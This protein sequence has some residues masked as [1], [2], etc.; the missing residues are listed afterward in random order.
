M[1]DK[2]QPSF[3]F[4]ASPH[5]LRPNLDHYVAATVSSLRSYYHVMPRGDDF[6][7]YAEFDKAYKVLNDK[8]NQFSAFTAELVCQA[9]EEDP[10]VF[11]VLRCILGFSPPELA[12]LAGTE[13]GLTITQGFARSLDQRARARKPLFRKSNDTVRKRVNA[14][15]RIACETI[16]VGAPQT[17]QTGLHRL[18]KVDTGGGLSTLKSVAREKVPYPMLLYERFLGRPF[19]S[20]R[21]AVSERVGDVIEAEIERQLHRYSVPFYKAGRASRIP[22]FDQA[23]D[24]LIPSHKSPRAVIEAKLTEDDGTARDKVTRVQHLRELADKGR[25]FEVIACIDGRGFT[26]RRGDMK[27]LLIAT[28]GK[29][30]TMAT[31]DRLIEATSLDQFRT[32]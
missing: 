18:T 10:L 20:H 5:D 4:E 7:E 25:Q 1:R 3:P 30:F 31:M 13:S 24:F 9:V 17:P 12:H 6:V 14:L 2:G 26:I 15:I 21:D 11:V 22:G 29:V 28:N 27:K 19:A 32:T 16:A 8:T 23:P